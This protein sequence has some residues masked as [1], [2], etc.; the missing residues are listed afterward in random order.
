M[1]DL[2]RYPLGNIGID[3]V[4]HNLFQSSPHASLKTGQWHPHKNHFNKITPL[5]NEQFHRIGS[6]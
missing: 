1:K 2:S 4:C 5:F 6:Q 3:Y